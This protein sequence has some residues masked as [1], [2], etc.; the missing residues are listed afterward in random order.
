MKQPN[1]TAEAVRK[2]RTFGALEQSRINTGL[3]AW[4][5]GRG[6]YGDRTLELVAAAAEERVDAERFPQ[7]RGHFAGWCVVRVTRSVKTKMGQAFLAGDLT[8]AK[9]Q[10]RDERYDLPAY[11]AAFSFR[12]G[13]TT[14]VG[15]DV[16]EISR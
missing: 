2:D 3:Q 1:I 10:P 14:S 16:E 6:P 4:L 15:L 9:Y 12:N 7:Y 5:D 8:I 13:A 11:W